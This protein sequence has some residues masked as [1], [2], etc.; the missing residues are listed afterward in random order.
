MFCLCY[1]WRRNIIS[2]SRV[3]ATKI[4]IESN[5]LPQVCKILDL[6][7]LRAMGQNVIAVVFSF[8]AGEPS[9]WIILQSMADT[10]VPGPK[11]L[12]QG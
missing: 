2:F 1:K 3:L 7:L 5:F 12:F 11:P 9:V 8:Q 4:A 6:A 10:P